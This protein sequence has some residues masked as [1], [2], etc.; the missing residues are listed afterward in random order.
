MKGIV[1]KGG[2]ITDT[3]YEINQSWF[4]GGEIMWNVTRA[5]YDALHGRFGV[6]RI[7]RWNVPVDR[8]NLDM[9]KVRMFRK[10]PEVLEAP[11]LVVGVMDMNGAEH[12]I[13]IDG[14]HRAAARMMNK[15]NDMIFWFIPVELEG[16]YRVTM[17]LIGD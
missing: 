10:M 11:G 17:E 13:F 5:M 1:I 8:R 15:T 4:R 14:N 6:P 3:I 7:E 16:E 2:K 9:K 12:H